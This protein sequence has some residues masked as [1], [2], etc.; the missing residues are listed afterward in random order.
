MLAVLM[1]LSITACNKNPEQGDIK[2]DSVIE[3]PE[4]T[5]NIPDNKEEEKVMYVAEY[6]DVLADTYEFIANIED[7]VGPDNGYFGGIWDA[8]IALGKEALEEIG[9]VFKDVNGDSVYEL[10]IGAFN[11]PDGAYTNNEIYELYTLKNNKPELLFFDWSRST[12]SLKED[13]SF[14]YQESDGAAYNIFG[15]YYMDETGEM[16][17]EYYFTYPD[18]NNPEIIDIYHNKTG[19]CYPELSK[20]I[21]ITLDDFW[22]LVEEAA[23]G[24]VKLSATA[25]SN[26]D[27]KI[28]EKALTVEPAPDSSLIVGESVQPSGDLSNTDNSTSYADHHWWE[29]SWW[30]GGWYG[31]WMVFDGDG[32][33]ADYINE[34]R[35]CCAYI[36]REDNS[37]LISIW[38]DVYNDA[39]NNCLA[40]VEVEIDLDKNVAT[41]VYNGINFFWFDDVEA[42]DWVIDQEDAGVD[43]MILI[44][45]SFTDA[46]GDYCEYGVVLTRWGYEW[47]EEDSTYPPPPDYYESY[48][49]PLMEDEEH[50]PWDFVPN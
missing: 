1:I 20:K 4:N 11:K 2:T 44:E 7:R 35:D 42:G 16:T 48:L 39:Y 28:V 40:E 3:Q 25:F 31:W 13:G 10:M 12:F 18:V 6:E 21:D 34:A 22:S 5:E 15:T 24:T 29:Y 45:G 38:D 33:Y 36:D 23:K 27:E 17:C 14:F 8:T 26:L 46:D 50:P 9:F 41:S 43:N 32:Y 30:E 37:H 49:L 19:A 47:N